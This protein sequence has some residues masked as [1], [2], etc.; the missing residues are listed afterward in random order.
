MKIGCVKEIKKHEYRVGLTPSCVAAY[1]ARGHSVAIQAGSG[2][3]AGFED[4]EYKKA[5]AVMVP[6][7]EKVYRDS[8][9]IVKVKEVQSSE[10][11]FCGRGRYFYLPPF[12][13]R[14]GP[15]QGPARA[16]GYRHRLRN[17]QTGGWQ[18]ALFGAHERNCRT[19]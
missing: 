9:M 18:S 3:G 16:E 6:E 10:Y 2:E 1:V 4:G 19:A 17:Y 8:Q 12:G 13:R 11:G 5:G 14:R 7:A 15:N